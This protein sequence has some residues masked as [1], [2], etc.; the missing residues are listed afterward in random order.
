MEPSKA[1]YPMSVVSEL[2][3]LTPR[4]IRYYESMGLINPE[5]SKGNQRLYTTEDVDTLLAIKALLAKGLTLEGIKS[6]IQQNGSDSL[7]KEDIYIPEI[8][9]SMIIHQMKQGQPLTSLY[10]VNNQ[11]TLQNLLHKRQR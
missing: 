9:H 8:N 5:R 1:V 2:T 10:P 6:V 7:P 4:Q 3:N 11:Q